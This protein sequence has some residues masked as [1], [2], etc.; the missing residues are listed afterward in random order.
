MN[1]LQYVLLADDDADDRALFTDVLRDLGLRPT[2][3]T[4]ED[5]EALMDFLQKAEAL[6]EVIL[7]DLIMPKKDGLACLKA[8]KADA[9][10]NTL[11]IIIFSTST[12]HT[13]VELTHQEGAT[14]F[15]RKP[16]GYTKMLKLIS[17]LF[18]LDKNSLKEQWALND[19]LLV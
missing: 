19:F 1:T 3:K 15:A 17:K 7:L 14:L 5:G 13:L 12:D 18:A 9:R 8:I 11:P 16:N 10:L 6:P 2:V 4:I